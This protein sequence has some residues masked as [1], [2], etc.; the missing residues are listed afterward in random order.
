MRVYVC[1]YFV[2]V[3]KIRLCH[4]Y[5]IYNYRETVIMTAADCIICF[6][7]NEGTIKTIPIIY[8]LIKLR[9]FSKEIICFS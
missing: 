5:H 3:N 7:L 1:N 6:A 4:V 8:L 9:L 2:V